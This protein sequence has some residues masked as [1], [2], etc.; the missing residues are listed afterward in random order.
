MDRGFFSKENINALFEK[1][2]K[3]L[4]SARM[5]LVFIQSNLES[6]YDNFCS[7]DCYLPEYEL[8]AQT[9]STTWEYKQER[10]YK[11]DT[12]AKEKRIYLHYY[13]NIEKAAE[14]KK[15]FDNRLIEYKDE[16]LSQ[17]PVKEHQSFYDKYFRVKQTP[18]R[19]VSVEI[20]TDEVDK[21]AKLYGFFVLLS[22]E[23]M[24][25][26]KAL[27]LYRNKDV[28]EKAFG[29]LKERLSMRRMLVSSEHSLNGKLFVEFIALIFL[30]YIK[31]Q[32]QI[33]N[34]YKKHTLQT[35]LDKVDL[36]EYFEYP[37]TKPRVGEVLEKQKEIY[38][39]MGVAVPR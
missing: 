10:P 33:K 28:V 36:I 23:K 22:N 14:D 37:N 32:M 2:L 9:V 18:K 25:A 35:L 6:I 4:V 8:Y 38:E 17:K 11:K 15:V 34:L 3:F 19:G 29:N 13:Y 24:D 1:H 16:L 5:S 21:A 26:T 31:K 30:S 39:A 27:Q 20:K 12:I 7:Y